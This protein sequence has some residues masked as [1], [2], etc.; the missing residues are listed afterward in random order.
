[1]EKLVVM[2]AFLPG[3]EGWEPYYNNPNLW[4]FRF[5][6]PTPEALVSGREKTYFAYFWN[7]LAA[8]RKRSVALADREAYVDAYSRP[9]RMG[10]AWAYF[11]A[12]LQTAADFS[13]LAKTKLTIPVL[14][15]AGEKASA[16]TLFPQ[17]KLVANDVTVPGLKDTGHWVPGNPTW[18]VPALALANSRVQSTKTPLP[19][20]PGGSIPSHGNRLPF[21]SDSRSRRPS[22]LGSLMRVPSVVTRSPA[23][24]PY[25][26]LHFLAD[27]DKGSRLLPTV[28]P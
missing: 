1:V 28:V 11:A 14:A 12:W 22:I 24:K 23:Y 8:D 10:A 26:V 3:V 25:L 13:E 6:G 7:D 5:N 19:I 4:H 2:D 27:C 17:M 9:G 16:A 20:R 18:H 15:I 21:A